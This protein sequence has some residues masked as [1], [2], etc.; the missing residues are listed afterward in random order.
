MEGLHCCLIF[1]E[2]PT[3][4]DFKQ[5]VIILY[6]KDL[7]LQNAICPFLWT[8]ENYLIMWVAKIG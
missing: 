1:C 3:H 6:R 4:N 7:H 2:I 5:V 8:V